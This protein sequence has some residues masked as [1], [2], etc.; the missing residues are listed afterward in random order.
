MG[1]PNGYTPRM[2]AQPAPTGVAP[3]P[4]A[5]LGRAQAVIE[6][7]PVPL[8][9]RIRLV[10][11]P[12]RASR[13]YRVAA[14]TPC[15]NRAIDIERLLSDM[16]RLD[17]RGIDLVVVVV[18]NASSVPLSQ[19]PTPPGLEVEHVRLNENR[20]GAGGFN[21]GM[22]HVLSGSG[23]WARRR[24]PDFIW[25][26]DSDARATKRC[27]RELIRAIR[28]RDD[29]AAVGSAL[30]DPLTKRVYEIGGKLQR[31]TGYYVPAAQ[32]SVDHRYLVEADYLAACSTLVRREAIRRT[33]LM[34]EIFINGDDVEWFLQMRAATGWRV[35]GA[36]RAIA[37]HPLPSRKFQTWVRYYTTRNSYAPLDCMGFG[38]VTR[39]TRGLVDTARA[40]AQAIMGLPEL[41]DLH[42][43][44]MADAAAG[45]TVGFGPKGG[46]APIAQSTRMTPFVSLAEQVR[47]SL[48]KRP[49]SRLFVHPILKVH[50][51][52][53]DGLREQLD[54]LEVRATEHDHVAWGKRSLGAHRFR[55]M[56]AAML[57]VL[58]PGKADVAIVPTG[59]PTGWFRGRTL[60]QITNDGYLVREITTRRS[61]GEAM[62]VIARGGLLALRLAM[63][64]R[65]CNPLPPAPD[66]SGE[67][68]F[69]ATN[70]GPNSVI[71]APVQS[72]AS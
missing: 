55:D 35:A 56:A 17:R 49:G 16:A 8:R 62:R 45:R 6:F 9:E 34:P 50:S 66:R 37:Y 52:D 23:I 61:V 15:F 38:R 13:R 54:L 64:R 18:D 53:F 2:T 42:L 32:G 5:E 48:M 24:E 72:T 25:I 36:P 65:Q 70:A 29:L 11:P 57:R 58:T 19:I 51:V 33:G 4:L 69:A 20:G 14:V 39:F 10:R 30:V 46:I 59:W 3:A 68:R 40:T 67:A 12:Q 44:G 1:M 21:A 28:S 27:L 22:A 26:L 47:A 63:R 31:F 41:A 7:K 60:F 71:Q 43:Q